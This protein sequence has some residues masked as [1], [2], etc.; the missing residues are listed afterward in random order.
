MA[1]RIAVLDI[2]R[3]WGVAEGIWSLRQHGWLQPHQIVEQPR[4][5]CV[6]WK[7]LGD[8]EPQFRA[9]WD[10]GGHYKLI[11][12]AHKILD[13]ATHIISWNGKRFDEPHLRSDFVRYGMTPPSPHKSI[14]LMVTAKRQFNFLSN[15]MASVADEL[16]LGGKYDHGGTGLWKKLRVEKGQALR[17]A[18]ETMRT[19]NLRDIELTEELWELLKPWCPSLNLPLY[20]DEAGM[21][22]YCPACESDNVQYRG[23]A[24]TSTR[25]YKRFQC[26]ECGR[27]GRD[28]KSVAGTAQVPL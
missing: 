11:E 6:A 18:R 14:D 4:T 24:R 5:I 20:N 3:T 7:W 27:W 19:Y 1:A 23:Y 2:E 8:E 16:G 28:L 12:T 21:G 9:E 26:N 25:V 22:P 15:R 13:E 17:E 10:R